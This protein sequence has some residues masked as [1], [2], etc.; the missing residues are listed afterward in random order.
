[1][2][3]TVHICEDV[4][5]DEF[6]DDAVL[7]HALEIIERHCAQREPE[8]GSY[9]YRRWAEVGKFVEKIALVL[10]VDMRKHE[11]PPMSTAARIKSLDELREHMSKSP[12]FSSAPAE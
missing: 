8:A 9:Y 6:E 7:E 4:S 10:G 3:R 11:L 1:M 12:L 5:L 2:R